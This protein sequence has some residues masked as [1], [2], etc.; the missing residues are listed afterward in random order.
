MKIVISPAKSLD[1]E[2]KIPTDNYSQP[3]FEKKTRQIQTQLKELSPKQ[4]TQLMGISEKLAELNWQRNQNFHLPFTPENARQAV[5]SFSGEVYVGLDVYTLN[6]KYIEKMQNSLRILSGLYGVLKPLD[7]IQAY[8][9]EMGTKIAI[10]NEKDLYD[11]WKE[12]L[13]AC[14]E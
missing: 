4:L 2:S 11:F 1:M 12:D 8:R 3:Q 6:P 5:Y 9:L 14:F 10:G 7:L 13:T